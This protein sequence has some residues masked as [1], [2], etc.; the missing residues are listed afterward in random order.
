[1]SRWPSLVSSLR[2]SEA[3]L[4]HAQPFQAKSIQIA[5]SKIGVAA[6]HL[7]FLMAHDALFEPERVS[8]AT[9]EWGRELFNTELKCSP[10]PSNA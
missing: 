1:M 8:H 5:Q 2:T 3:I 10:I 6:G 9:R 4:D 7:G